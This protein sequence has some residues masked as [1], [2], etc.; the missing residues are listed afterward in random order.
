MPPSS[1]SPS[2]PVP[3]ATLQFRSA[4]AAED[5]LLGFI[6]YELRT[7]YRQTTRSHDLD[8]FS[9]LL[10]E[11]GWDPKAVPAVHV[12]GTNGKGS[13][14]WILERILRAGGLRTG[15]YSSPH[16]R[17]MRERVRLGGRLIGATQ[18]KRS[19]AHITR[20]LGGGPGSG[21][22]T[23]FEHWTALAL[24]SFQD[25]AIERAVIEVGLG[26]KLDATNVIPAGPAILTPISMD[27]G[28]ILGGTLGAI[29]RDKAQILKRGGHGFIMPQA[30]EAF[31]PLRAHMR[32]H[33]IPYVRTE[34]LVAVEILEANATG[35]TLKIEGHRQDYGNVRTRLLGPHQVQN[36]GAAV[37]V[38]ENLLP[39]GRVPEAVREGLR[40]ALVPGRLEPLRWR[41]KR[42]L[43]DGGHNP[44]AGRA[45]AKALALHYPGRRVVAVV[46]MPRDKDHRGYLRALDPLVSTFFFTRAANPRAA[47][48]GDLAART[49]RGGRAFARVET[50]VEAALRSAAE[51][52]LVAGSFLVVAEALSFLRRRTG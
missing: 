3:A 16:L 23:T 18:F 52:V 34:E 17:T 15:L 9:R 7:G 50:A 11:L 28:N 8:R 36:V 33:R 46:G 20:T 6:N 13:V 39:R 2:S 41:G 47:L 19:V 10:G 21:F 44:A 12:G 26:G 1:P 30:R 4:Q 24:L 35:S 14:G 43:L 27:H 42:V 49:P 37:A 48:P 38:A 25:H 29:A 51:V 32:K 5:Y 22:R 40:G 31:R 45:V